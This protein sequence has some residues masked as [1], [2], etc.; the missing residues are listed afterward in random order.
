MG[1]FLTTH[2]WLNDTA[3]PFGRAP[4]VMSYDHDARALVTQDNRVWIAELNDEGG[5]GSFLAAAMK[6]A[7]QPQA[8]EVAKLEQFVDGV[9]W[10]RLQNA[11][12]TVRK[13]L[14]F[15]QPSLVPGFYNL[16]ISS[17][18]TKL[19]TAQH[20]LSFCS[21]D[22]CAKLSPHALLHFF[23]EL[24][25][26][27]TRLCGGSEGDFYKEVHAWDREVAPV[28]PRCVSLEVISMC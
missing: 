18:Q 5:A 4:S 28:L 12:Y 20:L 19:K 8:E 22:N 23:P 6:Q 21:W 11:D 27:A 14:F 16:P 10:G 17:C 15:Y 7:M 24:G 26:Q 1:R 13:S 9:L 25:S 3:D 2:Q